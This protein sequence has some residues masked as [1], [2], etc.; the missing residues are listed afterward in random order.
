MPNFIKAKCITFLVRWENMPAEST[1]LNS[2]I[3]LIIVSTYKINIFYLLFKSS[4]RFK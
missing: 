4:I 3:N 2:E 1:E